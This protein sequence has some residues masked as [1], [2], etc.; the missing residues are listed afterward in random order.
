MPL[1]LHLNPDHQTH[2]WIW[3]A[4]ESTDW[5]LK[6]TQESIHEQSL[7][8]IKS[9]QRV[10]EVV[11]T[12]LLMSLA[13][14]ATIKHD[15]NGR[16]YCS[17]YPYISISHSKQWIALATHTTSPIGIDIESHTPK[18]FKVAKR[19]MSPHELTYLPSEHLATMLAC[20][21]VKEAAYKIIGPSVVDFCASL[22]IEPFHVASEGEITVCEIKTSES[23][24]MHYLH[25]PH[26][27]LVYGTKE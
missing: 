17:E 19:Y 3:E 6:Q 7:A 12:H 11:V 18:V 25:N 10:R 21:C 26:Y 27:M 9:E 4:T 16:P 22:R 20:W 8:A 5:L 13:H 15:T 1:H 14:I 23:L 24:T 2:I